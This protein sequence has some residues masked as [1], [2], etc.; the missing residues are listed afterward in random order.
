M[1]KLN[2]IATKLGIAGLIGILLSVGMVIN[3]V[4]TESSISEAAHRVDLQR[5][6]SEMTLKAESGMKQI[7]SAARGIR[8]AKS[9]AE[10]SRSVAELHDANVA[11]M[12]VLDEALLV[13]VSPEDKELFD[14]IKSIMKDYASL[15]EDQA[16][17]RKSTLQ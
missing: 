15:A 1:T 6:I 13:A 14:R 7:Q 4:Q 11:E 16:K 3:E 9:D 12:K 17:L 5:H 8:V 2:R 10:M